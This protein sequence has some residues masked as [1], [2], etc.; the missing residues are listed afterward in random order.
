MKKTISA[1]I[2]SS[3]LA[4]SASSVLAQEESPTPLPLLSFTEAGA[5]EGTIP[6]METE[7]EKIA[8]TRRV[9]GAYTRASAEFKQRG[10]DGEWTVRP[11]YKYVWNNTTQGLYGRFVE[12]REREEFLKEV[13]GIKDKVEFQKVISSVSYDRVVRSL[14]QVSRAALQVGEEPLKWAV[15]FYRFTRFNDRDI[16]LASEYIASALKA[17][18]MNIVRANQWLEGN[19]KLEGDFSLA[20]LPANA[21]NQSFE[22]MLAANPSAA[23]QSA[24]SSYRAAITSTSLNAAVE[25]VARALKAVDLNLVRANQWVAFQKGE[26]EFDIDALSPSAE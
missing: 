6:S 16:K 1:L 7:L 14:L 25:N 21:Q 9:V 23:L 26:G 8:A 10:W 18:D 2:V 13:K 5:L 11:F 19:Y 12:S 15:A 24:I 4:Y 3:I 22:Y 17:E 20:A